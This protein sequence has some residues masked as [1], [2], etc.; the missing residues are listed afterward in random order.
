MPIPPFT[1]P[2]S[3]LVCSVSGGNTGGRDVCWRLCVKSDLIGGVGRSGGRGG[4]RGGWI[5]A[6]VFCILSV[7][8]MVNN[9]GLV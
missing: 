6:V 8:F 5:W 1:P 4:G 2:R 3:G 7:L 9:P